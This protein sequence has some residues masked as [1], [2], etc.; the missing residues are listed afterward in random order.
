MVP[1][2]NGNEKP[3][4][5]ADATK[6]AATEGQTATMTGTYKDPDERRGDA[7]RLARDGRRHRRRDVELVER[8]PPAE[9]SED[10]VYITATDSGGRKDQAV[11]FLDVQQLPISAGPTLTLTPLTD[12]NPVVRHAHAHREALRGHAAGRPEDPLH[13]RGHAHAQRIGDDGGRRHR[14]L[15][16]QRHEHRQRHDHR[17]PR[18]EQQRGL[19]D[20]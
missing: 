3:Y 13:G 17:L 15:R 11:F 4:V 6:V 9:P 20:R 16:L 18:R 12:T 7:Q 2:A 14:H 1:A 8:R 10:F 19:R 5:N